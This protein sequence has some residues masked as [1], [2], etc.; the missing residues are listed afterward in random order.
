M[1]SKCVQ[2][3][4]N[5]YVIKIRLRVVVRS[6]GEGSDYVFSFFKNDLC[7]TSD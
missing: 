2:E 4:S 7:P 1:T 6:D 3:F 5:E